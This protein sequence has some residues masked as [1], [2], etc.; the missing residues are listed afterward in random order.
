MSDEP[1]R[2]RSNYLGTIAGLPQIDWVGEQ[3]LLDLISADNERS[4][5]EDI[6]FILEQGPLSN[7]EFGRLP[8]GAGHDYLTFM[9]KELSRLG[10][11]GFA[12]GRAS[13]RIKSLDLV[14]DLMRPEGSTKWSASDAT[15]WG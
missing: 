3:R 14:G 10:R 11:S 7:D 13:L 8:V 2:S 5:V 9:R 4:P 15:E 6:P 1:L 12:E